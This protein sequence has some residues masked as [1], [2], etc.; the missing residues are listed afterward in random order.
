MD[1]VAELVMVVKVVHKTKE[2]VFYQVKKTADSIIKPLL[3]FSD[4]KST[5][6]SQTP[7]SLFVRLAEF[8]AQ[9]SVCA[10]TQIC[11]MISSRSTKEKLFPKGSVS[12]R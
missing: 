12:L 6:K 8:K 3:S 4:W 11:R 7:F 9:Q 2:Y 1:S 10:L 5:Q